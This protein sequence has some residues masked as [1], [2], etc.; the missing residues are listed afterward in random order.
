MYNTFMMLAGYYVI[1]N[2]SVFTSEHILDPQSN[3]II[4]WVHKCIPD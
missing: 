4:M 1:K 3:N 2:L